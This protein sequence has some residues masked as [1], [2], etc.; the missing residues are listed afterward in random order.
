MPDRFVNLAREM[1]EIGRG[2]YARGWV[3]GTGS[4]PVRHTAC[5]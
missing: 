1:A 2:F 3:L 5:G 4:R